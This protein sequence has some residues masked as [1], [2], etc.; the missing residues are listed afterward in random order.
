MFF[1]LVFW[2]LSTDIKPCSLTLM[3]V[4][5]TPI[6]SVFGFLPTETKTCSYCL[7]ISSPF[8]S[9]VTSIAPDFACSTFVIFVD[10]CISLNSFFSFLA[11]G[12]TKSGSAPGRR[13]GR[14]SATLTLEPKALKTVPISKPI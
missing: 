3:F 6:F 5:S 11:K 10:K 14:N 7:V 13:L 1:T 4:L 12:F 2:Y 9:I 8:F